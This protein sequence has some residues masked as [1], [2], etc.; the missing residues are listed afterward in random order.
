MDVLL[1]GLLNAFALSR[2][3]YLYLLFSGEELVPLDKWVFNTEAHPLPV[4]EWSEWEM[5]WF[6][7]TRPFDESQFLNDTSAKVPE[8]KTQPDMTHGAAPPPQA[9]PGSAHG[10]GRKP[11][12]LEAG[13][14]NVGPGS[15]WEAEQDHG[16]LDLDVNFDDA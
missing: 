10:S 4:Y 14:A 5:E 2:L 9:R 7:L 6:N 13:A 16:A 15:D 12:V 11:V 3:K 1:E 8:V